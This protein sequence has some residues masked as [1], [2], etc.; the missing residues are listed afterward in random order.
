[1]LYLFALGMLCAFGP[2]CT[3]IYLPGLPQIAADFGIDASAAQL[4][5]TASFLGLAFGQVFIGPLSDAIGRKIPLMLSLVVFA[6]TS[7]LCAL[8]ESIWM[9]VVWRFFQGVAGSGGL[10]LS[11]SIACDC[12]QGLE[13]TR[14]M[15]LLMTINSVAPILGPIIG[16]LIVT[17]ASWQ[18]T[19]WFL[20]VWGALLVV[21]C[22]IKVPE[23]LEAEKRE[24]KILLSFVSMFR[25]LLNLRFLL[26]VVSLS[27]IMGGFFSYLAA[28]PF[29]F[30]IIYGFSPLQYSVTFGLIAFSI[31][32]S[33]L[34]G[35][36]LAARMGEYRTISLAYILMFFSGT[37]VLCCAL[38]EAGSFVPILL[39]LVVFCSMMGV[40]NTV[41]FGL[42]MASRKGGAGAASG[43]LGVMNFVFGAV[44]SPLVGLMGDHSMIP[45]G[46]SLFLSSILAYTTFVLATKC[47]RR[48]Y[49]Q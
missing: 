23:S 30:Q 37:D 19:F 25:E 46:I 14:F 15:S 29:V 36:R 40:C 2:L 12:F 48:G 41:G 4:S 49:A 24:S 9:L 8:S 13:L 21:L 6:L 22:L 39:G 47:K 42:V 34:L 18:M 7:A 31:S 45:F 3:D 1:M 38:V 32:I 26:Y 5:L 33:A 20:T 10:V 44:I 43:I 16:S 17:F 28:S 35:A 27:F 11:R